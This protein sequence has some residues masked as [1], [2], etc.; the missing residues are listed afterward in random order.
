MTEAAIFLALALA[1]AWM[2]DSWSVRRPVTA[3]AFGAGIYG[4]AQHGWQGWGWNAG[5]AI[6]Y[7]C[8]TVSVLIGLALIY[9]REFSPDAPDTDELAYGVLWAGL[10]QGVVIG[11]LLPV[12]PALALFA[13]PLLHLPNGFLVGVTALGGGVVVLTSVVYEPSIPA[14]ALMHAVV[15]L[16]I[17]KGLPRRIHH[18]MCV[19][20]D[21]LAQKV[22]IL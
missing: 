9:G 20:W 1:A 22:R 21:C 17:S 18:G 11:L 14:A 2:P 7:L 6:L 10:Q 8:F 16:A 3:L 19:G 4:M 15:S 5:V 13:F 12:H